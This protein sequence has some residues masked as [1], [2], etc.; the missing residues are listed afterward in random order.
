MVAGVAETLPVVSPR[1][2]IGSIAARAGDVA[3][4]AVAVNTSQ[5]D[6]VRALRFVM[7]SRGFMVPS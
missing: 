7:F 3:Q 6:T 2:S 5:A 1:H 4:K